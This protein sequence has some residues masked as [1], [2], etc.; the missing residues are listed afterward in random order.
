MPNAGYI[1]HKLEEKQLRQVW[2]DVDAIRADFSKATRHQSEVVGNMEHTYLL[3]EKTRLHLEYLL[4]PL[5]RK[6]HDGFPLQLR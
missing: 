6:L 1:E 5:T 3:S 4:M 2:T